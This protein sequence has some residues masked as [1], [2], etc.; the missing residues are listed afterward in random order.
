MNPT[1][2]QQGAIEMAVWSTL[3]KRR[4]FGKHVEEDE[5]ELLE[6]DLRAAIR[7]ALDA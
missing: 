7:A 4:W 3:V 2:D 5:M 6:T 1:S